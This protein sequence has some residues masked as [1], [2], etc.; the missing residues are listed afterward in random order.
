MVSR[1]NEIARQNRLTEREGQIVKT[2]FGIGREKPYTVEKVGEILNTDHLTVE[3]TK[4]EALQKLYD[5]GITTGRINPMNRASDLTVKQ[6]RR[7]I[8][9]LNPELLVN[10][11]KCLPLFQ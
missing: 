4:K 10:T 11:T 5:F 1:L 7:L 8:K 3:R 9:A 2:Q 6:I